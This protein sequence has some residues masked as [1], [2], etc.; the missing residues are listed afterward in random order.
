MPNCTS[1]ELPLCFPAE[2][3]LEVFEGLR[4]KERLDGIRAPAVAVSEV[5]G[6]EDSPVLS[7]T[8]SAT[9][10]GLERMPPR[11]N[12]STHERGTLT[13]EK[14]TALE[15]T[16]GSSKDSLRSQLIFQSWMIDK[17]PGLKCTILGASGT[18]RKRKVALPRGYRSKEYDT[19][20]VH[21]GQ[22]L[23]AIVYRYYNERFTEKVRE[24]ALKNDKKIRAGRLKGSNKDME[25]WTPGGG[26]GINFVAGEGIIQKRHEYL[27]PAP[28]VAGYQNLHASNEEIRVLWYDNFLEDRWCEKDTWD[29]DVEIVVNAKGDAEWNVVQT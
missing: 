21:A 22:D 17:P 2:Y 9:K 24:D 28:M 11:K 19:I 10:E 8:L 25:G 4:A 15:S 20:E 18:G 23:N 27:G 1:L 26:F 3:A 29:V 13:P 5:L 7:T 6:L 16:K 12:M 14:I